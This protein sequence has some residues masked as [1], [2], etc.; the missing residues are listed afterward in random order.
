MSGHSQDD[1]GLD[2]GI[3]RLTPWADDDAQWYA[4]STR[5]PSIQQ[6]TT[7]SPALDAA[8]VLTAIRHLRTDRAAEGFLIRDA[9][10]NERLGNIALHHDRSSGEVSYW[11]AAEARGRGVASR[12][13]TL[14]SQW[15][16]DALGLREVWLCA[17]EDN[18]PSQRAALNAGFQRDASRDKPMEAKGAIWPMLGYVLAR[19]DN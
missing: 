19:S 8:Q 4:A 14:F 17:H 6:F 16:L 18:I 13:L 5:D 7:E 1:H 3:V 15:S 11:V 9:A 12:A 2:D 10:T